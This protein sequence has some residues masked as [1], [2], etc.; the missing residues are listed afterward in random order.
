M[1]EERIYVIKQQD[2]AIFRQIR[3]I[4]KSNEYF[5]SYII[6]VD[7]R[8]YKTLLGEL[9]LLLKNGFKYNQREYVLT[10]RSA[11]MVRNGIV[12]FVDKKVSQEL[13]QIVTMDLNLD[14]V[15][16][17][18]Y[19]A[20]RGL[21]FSSCFFIEDTLPYIIIVDDYKTIIPKQNIKYVIEKELIY[22]DKETNEKRS[23]IN[24]EIAEGIKDITISPADGSGLNSPQIAGYWADYLGIGYNPCLFMIRMPFVKGLS[25]TVD[26]KRFYADRGIE[27]ITDIW[28][29]EH[30][31][32]KVDCIWTRS[33]YKGY[34]Y[35]STNNDYSDWVHYQ[36]IFYKYHHALGISK[37]NFKYED[38]PIYTRVNYQYLQTLDITSDEMIELADYSKQWVE[39][40][41]NGDEVYT[42]SFLGLNTNSTN[43]QNKYM[44]A[45]L[46][47]PQMLHDKRVQDYL[48][49]LLKK[50][51]QEFKIGKVWIKGNFKVVIPDLIML[52]EFIGGLEVVGCLNEGEF[53]GYGLE[54]KEHLIDRNPHI[55]RSEHTILRG[56]K[57]ELINT[58]LSHLENVCMLNGKDA[59]LSRLNGADTDRLVAVPSYR[60]IC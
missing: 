38:E 31:V 16:I 57:N 41:I 29:Q 54:D 1:V 60:N 28:G 20:Y 59:T 50:Y 30:D 2:N 3:R 46:L 39:K 37:W 21:M 43:P 9:E 48:Y 44:K 42:Y 49:K 22:T 26:F 17:S 12:G 58:Y 35:F 47:H 11:S 25:I 36:E 45:V 8:G 7:T 33:M 55:C 5:N 10:E 32:Q 4:T 52:M 13:N 56:V 18:K 6:F 15:I 14:K 34:K 53:Y 19:I 27:Y 40:I 24:K 51:I 23:Y